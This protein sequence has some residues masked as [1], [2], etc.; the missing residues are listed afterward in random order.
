MR[1][2]LAQTS[3]GPD[4]PRS[5]G[6]P[7]RPADRQPAVRTACGHARYTKGCD[8]CALVGIYQDHLSRPGITPAERSKV[9]RLYVAGDKAAL[10]KLWQAWRD[11]GS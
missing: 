6:A 7:P 4:T 5:D 3:R 8:I 10:F 11:S 2:P 1:Q 9:M